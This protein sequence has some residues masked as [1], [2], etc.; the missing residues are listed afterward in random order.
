MPYGL[1]AFTK[2]QLDIVSTVP[3]ILLQS[4]DIYE[5]DRI[6]NTSLTSQTF[7]VIQSNPK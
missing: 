3:N 7:V 5:M 2:L 4:V 6:C 1:A